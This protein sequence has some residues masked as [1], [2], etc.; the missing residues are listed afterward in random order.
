M[1]VVEYILVYVCVSLLYYYTIFLAHYSINSSSSFPVFRFFSFPNTFVVMKAIKCLIQPLFPKRRPMDNVLLDMDLPQEDEYAAMLLSGGISP[2]LQ[3]FF[4]Q[5]SQQKILS[6]YGTFSTT[7]KNEADVELESLSRK[8]E[9]AG[10]F[11]FNLQSEASE[12]LHRDEKLWKNAWCKFLRR[13][14]YDQKGMNRRFI[15]KS[16]SH[17]SRIPILLNI[18]PDAQFI[19][20]HRNPYE[21]FQSTAYMIPSVN[22]LFCL[23]DLPTSSEVLGYLISQYLE[24][25]RSYFNAKSLIPPGNLVEVAYS[26]LMSDPMF[27]IERIYSSLGLMP[28]PR[29]K[30]QAYLQSQEESFQKNPPYV[31]LSI[32]SRNTLRS[33]W[34]EVIQKLGY[35]GQL[36]LLDR[37]LMQHNS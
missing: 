2:F 28:F 11:S 1:S 25:H 4:L 5:E 23:T 24:M 20:V 29:D 30:I 21:V 33:K 37:Q 26:N 22:S 36:D 9:S 12:Q 7:P 3:F 16:P 6:Q 13:V 14:F 35:T 18:F 19:F 27:E 34:A 17:T 31:E 10:S 15:L 8:R 32:E